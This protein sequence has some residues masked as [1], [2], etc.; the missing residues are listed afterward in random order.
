MIRRKYPITVSMQSQGEVQKSSVLSDHLNYK[1]LKGYYGILAWW[2]Q[3]QTACPLFKKSITC[4]VSEMFKNWEKSSVSHSSMCCL[5]LVVRSTA[6][7]QK[8]SVHCDIKTEKSSKSSNL[9]RW[10]QQRP[11]L[12]FEMWLTLMN[13]WCVTNSVNSGWIQKHISH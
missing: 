12:E 9:R 11:L 13:H 4:F 3:K 1:M 8:Y 6:E 2:H 10:K 5:C 7:P